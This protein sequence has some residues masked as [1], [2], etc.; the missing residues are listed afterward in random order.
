MVYAYIRVSTEKQTVENQRHEIES[1]GYKIDQWVEETR[2]G[3]TNYKDRVLYKG[4][5]KKLKS[6]DILVC[7]EISR[8]G[9]SLYM[10]I[11]IMNYIISKKAKLITVK[12]NFQLDNS[13]NSKVV[14]FAFGLTAEI[15]RNLISQRTKEA[16]ALKKAKGIKLGRPIG[17]HNKHHKLENY[18]DYIIKKKQ[19]GK[20]NNYIRK[21]LHCHINTLKTYLALVD[22]AKIEG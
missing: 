14:S 3:T 1:H 19:E 15:E 21:H 6:G 16:L 12:E 13:I 18:K 11:E 9:R 5:M 17:S 8:L 10:V 20:S 7:S 2:S 22:K 4:I